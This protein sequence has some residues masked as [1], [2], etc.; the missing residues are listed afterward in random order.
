MYIRCSFTGVIL[1]VSRNLLFDI[2]DEQIGKYFQKFGAVESALAV[3]DPRTRLCRGSAFVRYESAESARACLDSFARHRQQQQ[4]STLPEDEADSPSNASNADD[5]QFRIGER[6]VFVCAALTRERLAQL[7]HER[8]AGLGTSPAE[9]HDI[10]D[11]PLGDSRRRTHLK[12]KHRDV[13]NMSLSLVGG[14]H[15]TS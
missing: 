8:E 9:G 1:N 14:V 6:E 3:R 7:R 2:S 5:A 4:R 15:L 11:D 12:P 13:R 10:D